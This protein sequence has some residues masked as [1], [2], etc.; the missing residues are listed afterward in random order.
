M[1]QENDKVQHTAEKTKKKSGDIEN[2]LNVL[3]AGVLGAN[4]GIISTAGLVIGV[5]SATTNMMTVLI[6]GLAGL[7]AGA[8]SMAGGEYSSVSTQK[9]VEKSEVEKEKKRLKEDFAGAEAELAEYYQNG[10]L[11]P[12]LSQQVANELMKEDALAARVKAKLNITLGEYVNPWSAAFSSIISFSCGAIIPLLFILFLPELYKIWGT[13]AAV[14]L[15][16]ALTGFISAA[17]GGAPRLKAVIRNVIVG[18]LTMAV[19]YGLGQFVHI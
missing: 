15:A 13:F 18:M 4:D 10:G 19:T 1:A 11:S 8:F 9:D 12:E 3:R 14:S 6:A 2:R 16:L 7:L 5:A 17:L